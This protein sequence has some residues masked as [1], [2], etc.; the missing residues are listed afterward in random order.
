MPQ[1]LEPGAQNCSFGMTDL[2]PSRVPSVNDFR[3]CTMTMVPP[4]WRLA[5]APWTLFVFSSRKNYIDI[6]ARNLSAS[7]LGAATATGQVLRHRGGSLPS[8]ISPTFGYSAGVR[9]QCTTNRDVTLSILLG[10][11]LDFNLNN[12]FFY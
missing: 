11:G 1:V 8:S 7:P 5:A 6:I 3:Y 4:L 2:P 10:T 9:V 12:K